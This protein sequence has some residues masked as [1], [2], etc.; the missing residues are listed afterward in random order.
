[1]PPFLGYGLVGN[2]GV[3]RLSEPVRRG[4]PPPQPVFVRVGVGGSVHRASHWKSERGTICAP[5]IRSLGETAFA[6]RM[7]RLWAKCRSARCA[8]RHA[9]F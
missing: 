4:A 8:D 9:T 5:C 2:G 6:F 1:M 7:V 3:R